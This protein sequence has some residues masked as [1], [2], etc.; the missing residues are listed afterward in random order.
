M[1]GTLGTPTAASAVTFDLVG[2]STLQHLNT[3]NA[4][5]N[6]CEFTNSTTTWAV[7]GRFSTSSG[8][9]DWTGQDKLDIVARV[10]ALSTSFSPRCGDNWRAGNAED[11]PLVF[12]IQDGNPAAFLRITP[13]LVGSISQTTGSSPSTSTLVVDM[14]M[15]VRVN[16]QVVS[17]DRYS[18]VNDQ[19]SGQNA[20]FT[21]AFPKGNLNTVVLPGAAVTGTEV[22]VSLFAYFRV[23]ANG[24]WSI[25]GS[26]LNGNEVG[27]L[28]TAEVVGPV[29]VEAEPQ[30]PLSLGVRPNPSAGEPRIS[31]TLPKASEVQLSVYDI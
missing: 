31:Y 30:A 25:I 7:N 21:L 10:P 16:G 22:S 20:S 3:Y 24:I 18:L 6:F 23:M 2:E 13:R 27:I 19:T 29:G 28:V 8:T 12:P 5:G 15:T 14:R 4:F 17:T 9:L 26:G 1:L 11:S